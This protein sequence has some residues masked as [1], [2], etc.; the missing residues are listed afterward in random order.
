MSDEIT[1]DDIQIGGTADIRWEN[2]GKNKGKVT[3]IYPAVLQK[4]RVK[5]G[6]I[7]YL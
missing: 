1:V 2:K 4:S 7:Q 3:Q 6:I 5:N